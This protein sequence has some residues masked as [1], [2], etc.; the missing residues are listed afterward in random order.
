MNSQS[1]AQQPPQDDESGLA[2]RRAPPVVDAEVIG[3]EPSPAADPSG[4][5]ASA[6]AEGVMAKLQ[7]LL[8]TAH[9]AFT[10]HPAAAGETY[11]QHLWF[12]LSMGARLMM[13]GFVILLHGILPFTLTYTG[14][15]MLKKCNKIL[16]ERAIKAQMPCE[17]PMPFGDNI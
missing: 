16:S 2:A 8:D 15:N 5:P 9:R 17:S 4:R 14:S 6:Q 7:P 11:W 10:E 1:T 13:A 3:E 12:T